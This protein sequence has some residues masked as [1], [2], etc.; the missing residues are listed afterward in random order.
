MPTKSS[1]YSE[2]APVGT[3]SLC[4]LE[5]HSLQL[6]KTTLTF[7]TMAHSCDLQH[8]RLQMLISIIQ[9]ENYGSIQTRCE[10]RSK[11]TRFGWTKAQ[12]VP[13]AGVGGF[14]IF[15]MSPLIGFTVSLCA[16]LSLT[17]N[18]PAWPEGSLSAS[19]AISLWRFAF[20]WSHLLWSHRE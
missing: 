11:G 18:P 5:Q 8:C 14:S 7:K 2:R 9:E 1:S 20:V 15:S 12:R 17:K 19:L 4:S 10:H 13:R 6:M 16:S 3:L